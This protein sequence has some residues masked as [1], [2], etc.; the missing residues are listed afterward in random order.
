MK[1]QT[2]HNKSSK[3]QRIPTNRFHSEFLENEER[4]MIQHVRK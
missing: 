2:V 1:R 4:L 3:R